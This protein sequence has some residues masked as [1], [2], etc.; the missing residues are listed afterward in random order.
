MK[1]EKNARLRFLSAYFFSLW[2]QSR[3]AYYPLDLNRRPS[4]VF[5]PYLNEKKSHNVL[6][7]EQLLVIFLSNR[8]SLNEEELI[9]CPHILITYESCLSLLAFQINTDTPLA[10]LHFFSTNTPSRS[11]PYLH[12]IETFFSILQAFPIRL[13]N[14][15]HQRHVKD[16]IA[17]VD[18]RRHNIVHC[19]AALTW[20]FRKRLVDLER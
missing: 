14:W 12:Y 16:G 8:T 3:I 5:T 2:R 15:T 9:F 18:V 7:K 17:T 13:E 11:I 1:S 4:Y 10:S 19:H 6:A 20:Y